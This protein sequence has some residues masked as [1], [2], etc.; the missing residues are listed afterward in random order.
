LKVKVM[1][2]IIF[3]VV[4][5][6]IAAFAGCLKP[7]S[8]ELA[9]SHIPKVNIEASAWAAGPPT[10]VNLAELAKAEQGPVRR[11][12]ISELEPQH[13]APMIGYVAVGRQEKLPLPPIPNY[14]IV[15]LSMPP[16]PALQES[17]ELPASLHAPEV[18]TRLELGPAVTEPPPL[19]AAVPKVSDVQ[20]WLGYVQQQ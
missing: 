20:P 9:Q 1:R 10:T 4:V 13:Q 19:T 14:Q 18:S 3:A 11:S 12:P 17:V 6:G 8:A 15:R 5:A 16:V 2:N 7:S